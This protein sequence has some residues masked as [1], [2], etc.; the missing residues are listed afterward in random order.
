MQKLSIFLLAVLLLV[1]FVSCNSTPE[2]QED[3]LTQVCFGNGSGSKS[4]TSEATHKTASEL[5]WRYTAVKKD[6]GGTT[7]NT[8]AGITNSKPVVTDSAQTPEWK[9]GLTSNIEGDKY[10]HEFSVGKWEFTLYGF[11]ENTG[12]SGT[13]ESTYLYSGSA[14]ATAVASTVITVTIGVSPVSSGT[15]NGTI[16]VTDCQ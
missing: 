9:K 10:I 14:Q 3:T 2:V 16:S 5:Y 11:T 6:N 7:G 12:A 15:G 4:L 13:W 8:G 1:T